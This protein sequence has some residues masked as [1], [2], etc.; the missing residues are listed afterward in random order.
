MKAGLKLEEQ[1]IGPKSNVRILEV[2]LDSI[3]RWQPHLQAV[4]AKSV[5]LVNSLRTITGSTWGCS[6]ETGREIYKTAVRPAITY[7]A[8][9]W[10]TPEGVQGHCKGISKKLQTIQGKCL[11]TIMGAYKATSTEALEVEVFI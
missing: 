11:H 8:S 1:E 2:Q 6:L 3:L 7:G 4:E 5:H 10:H 9:V